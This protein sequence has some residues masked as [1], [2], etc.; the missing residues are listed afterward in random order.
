MSKFLKKNIYIKIAIVV[1]TILV[2]MIPVDMIITLIEEREAVHLDAISEVSSKWARNQSITGPF[3]CIPYSKVYQVTKDDSTYVNISSKREFLYI[4]PEYL[5]INTDIKPEKRYRGIYEVV[6][7]E[8]KINIYANFG[9]IKLSDQNM[10][11]HHFFF[12]KATLNIGITDLK[13]IEKQIKLKWNGRE[14]I[15]NPG[16]STDDIVRSGI[17]CPVNI[18]TGN[19]KEYQ[20]SMSIDLKGSQSLFFTPLG[21]TTDVEARSSWEN[22]SFDGEFL[23]D[24]REISQNGFIAK[25]NILHLNRNFPQSWTGK[26]YSLERS[27]FGVDLIV[28]VDR[29]LKTMRV[30]KYAIL[31]LSLTFTVFFFVEIL[32]KVFIHPIQYFLVGVALVIFFSLLL[33]LTEHIIFNISY[34][35]AS[36]ATIILIYLYILAILRSKQVALLLLGILAVTFSFIFTIIQLQDYALL[37]GSI[38]IFAILAL[39]MYVSRKIDWYDINISNNNAKE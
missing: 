8:S 33:S 16:V 39:V 26:Q 5:Q 1:I 28:P 32:K 11:N 12:E 37:I 31:F 21:K 24:S 14:T 6:V 23:P 13:G 36:L 29:Y 18:N 30:A 9:T 4:M 34:L 38:G 27:S 3:I 20:Y 2:L 19:D 22:P 10:E 7:Y 17:N 15:F 35:I 25:W